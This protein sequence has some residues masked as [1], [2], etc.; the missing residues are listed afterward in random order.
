MT[1]QDFFNNLSEKPV[2]LYS[3]KG[4]LDGI[5]WRVPKGMNCPLVQTNQP[6]EVIDLTIWWEDIALHS[7]PATECYARETRGIKVKNFFS[8]ELTKAESFILPMDRETCKNLIN[9]RKTPDGQPLLRI[10]DGYFG[11]SNIPDPQ[12]SWA[13]MGIDTVKNYYFV[14]M[15]VV[16]NNQDDTIQSNTKLIDK[17]YY[18]EGQCAT[19]YGL[20]IW[21]PAAVKTCRL[22]QGQTTTCLK[23]GNR[24]S[25]PELALAMTEWE[26]I[27][28]CKHNFA[29]STQGII[30]TQDKIWQDG[31]AITAK[32]DEVEM[33]L[34]R[35]EAER[36]E[37][38]KRYKRET[39]VSTQT[40]MNA[41]FQF[42]YD[43]LATNL[44][45]GIQQVHHDICR[46]NKMMLE[47]LRI[48][49]QGGSPSLLVR[50]LMGSDDYRARLNGDVVAIWECDKVYNYMMQQRSDCTVEWPVT[51]MEGHDKKFGF[52]SPLSHEIVEKAT[53]IPCPAPDFYFDVG[54]Y[55]IQLTNKTVTTNLPILPKPMMTSN[56]TGMP[57]LS[58]KTPGVYS[59]SEIT[60]RETLLELSRDIGNRYMLDSAILN[61]QKG[62]N[63][64]VPEF[65]V[66]EALKA[67][68]INPLKSWLSQIITAVAATALTSL[69]IYEIIV[70][71]RRLIRFF[72]KKCR[73]YRE[74]ARKLK[75]QRIK[76]RLAR[77]TKKLQRKKAVTES[78]T[79]EGEIIELVEDISPNEEEK[80]MYPSLAVEIEEPKRYRAKIKRKTQRASTYRKRPAPRVPR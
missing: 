34:I 47:T 42:L 33:M 32:T 53:P 70:N 21:N 56:L 64:S 69:L 2:P 6:S 36:K 14:D 31:K 13:R 66:L 49:A 29:V 71:R 9:L 73:S 59:L 45:F 19:E 61:M 75:Q 4:W 58:F 40:E 20:L 25:C 67:Y 51:Y 22:K 62:S 63:L 77:K 12:A 80:T 27:K 15:F 23:T 35:Q 55:V 8:D 16:V 17:C 60:G 46:T 7:V 24:I 52:I 79:S 5:K 50:V 30:F 78:D 72:N 74:K 18:N 38:K 43:I 68:T 44:T 39:R 57:K 1:T 26:Q 76:R 11:T 48:L 10:Q 37:A 3:C 28:L 65:N 41:R 54:D